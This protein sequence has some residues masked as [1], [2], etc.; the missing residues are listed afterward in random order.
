M[1]ITV[2]RSRPE[3]WFLVFRGIAVERRRLPAPQPQLA[4]ATK[5]VAR[6]VVRHETCRIKH[7]VNFER[8]VLVMRWLRMRQEQMVPAFMREG[9]DERPPEREHDFVE[10]A[11][12]G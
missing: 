2:S 3:S 7:V 4:E 12:V 10:R 1:S 11:V 8:A 5:A 6:R 9:A